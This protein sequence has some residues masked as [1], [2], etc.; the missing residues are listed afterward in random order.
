MPCGEGH[1][2]PNN[3]ELRVTAVK[4]RRGATN[5][6]RT[7]A[8]RTLEGL[9]TFAHICGPGISQFP[10]G[11]SLLKHRTECI[12]QSA[13]NTFPSRS[14]RRVLVRAHTCFHLPP[15]LWLGLGGQKSTLTHSNSS[16]KYNWACIPAHKLYRL[17]GVTSK[18]PRKLLLTG[19]GE[20]ICCNTYNGSRWLTAPA[21]PV[22]ISRPAKTFH[23]TFHGRSAPGGSEDNTWDMEHKFR[24]S[25]PSR[26]VLLQEGPL[27]PVHSIESSMQAVPFLVKILL[28][29]L[30][31]WLWLR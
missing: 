3:L 30:A 11:H 15:G 12:N 6:V 8:I 1:R 13:S 21:I 4:L 22:T 24:S 23:N 31:S 14:T 19:T 10:L 16:W 20:T 17:V 25:G 5:S 18:S 29:E 27:Y 9:P 28:S 7:W 2:L 26:A